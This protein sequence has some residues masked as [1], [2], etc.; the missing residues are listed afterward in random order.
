M[1]TNRLNVHKRNKLSSISWHKSSQKPIILDFKDNIG[2]LEMEFGIRRNICYLYVLLNLSLVLS[3]QVFMLF[4]KFCNQ[5]LFL[6][7]LLLLN[8]E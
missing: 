6:D 8:Q 4:L 2:L 3:G 5:E 1:H 7:L